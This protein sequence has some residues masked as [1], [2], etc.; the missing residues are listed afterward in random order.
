[1]EYASSHHKHLCTFLLVGPSCSQE[2]RVIARHEHSSTCTISR[3]PISMD[4]MGEKAAAE[5]TR[6]R[7]Q[8]RASI[9]NKKVVR[10]HKIFGLAR[11]EPQTW[12]RRRKEQRF[13]Q[14]EAVSFYGFGCG[15]RAQQETRTSETGD[16]GLA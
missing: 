2:Q 5:P 3:R 7:V 12:R 13:R 10:N 6:A 8:A 4:I 11:S 15:G 9:V 16:A 14:N 1:M